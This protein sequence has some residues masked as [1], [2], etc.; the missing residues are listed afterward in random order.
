MII[1]HKNKFIFIRPYK[2]AG[3]SLEY[4]M[5]PFLGRDDIVCELGKDEEKKRMME[6][7]LGERN[8]KKTLEDNVLS[9]MQSD[10]KLKHKLQHDFY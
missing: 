4:A 1:S 3:T 6:F 7:G 10:M 9:N 8:N 2:V 5:T